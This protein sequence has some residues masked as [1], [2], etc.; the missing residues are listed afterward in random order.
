MFM[1]SSMFDAASELVL[2]TIPNSLS[3]R[4]RHLQLVNRFYKDD[5]SEKE[6][7]SIEKWIIKNTE[8]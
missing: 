1:C 7:G 5:F 2:S 8:E 6:M 4:K 3:P